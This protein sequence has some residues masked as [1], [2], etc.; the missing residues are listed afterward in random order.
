MAAFI[1]VLRHTLELAPA[2]DALVELEARLSPPDETQRPPLKAPAIARLSKGSRR[3]RRGLTP[4]TTL[5]AFRDDLRFLRL[6]ERGAAW[7]AEALDDLAANVLVA[8][9]PPRGRSLG[10][11]DSPSKVTPLRPKRRG[12]PPGDA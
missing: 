6:F 12:R 8:P 2:S 4:E 1:G 10:A 7:P 9:V 3:L 11:T 5:D